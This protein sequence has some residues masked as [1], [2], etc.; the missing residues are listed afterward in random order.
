MLQ[1]CA[2]GADGWGLLGAWCLV[3][4][5][6]PYQPEVKLTVLDRG[7]F[8]TWLFL[9]TLVHQSASRG[10]V[11]CCSLHQ[12]NC[13]SIVFEI[14]RAYTWCCSTL[15]LVETGYLG[16]FFRIK[17]FFLLYFVLCM[18]EMAPAAVIRIHSVVSCLLR[19]SSSTMAVNITFACLMK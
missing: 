4:T 17:I 14:L 1:E 10:C 11:D 6:K 18:K 8:F 12:V 2:S 16:C 9:C 15:L 19:I 5:L 3:S 7:N 13:L